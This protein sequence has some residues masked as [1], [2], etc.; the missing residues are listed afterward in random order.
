MICAVG[1]C[2]KLTGHLRSP[3]S[4]IHSS[5]LTLRLGEG[6]LSKSCLCMLCMCMLCVSE[7]GGQPPLFDRGQSFTH[8]P[9]AHHLWL[10]LLYSIA[11][12]QGVNDEQV[13]LCPLSISGGCS[14][15]D[16]RGTT[17]TNRSLTADQTRG[18]A[19]VARPDKTSGR[20]QRSS[21]RQPPAF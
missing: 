17:N 18:G 1:H 9:A 11:T 13:K 6:G 21:C 5:L 7:G 8:S 16:A 10:Q 12:L 3:G 20:Q 15:S 4:Y 2:T 14:P 19:W